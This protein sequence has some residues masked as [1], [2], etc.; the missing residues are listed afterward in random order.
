MIRGSHSR[1][2]RR[3]SNRRRDISILYGEPHMSVANTLRAALYRFGFHDIQ[4]FTSLPPLADAISGQNPDLVILDMALPGGDSC[5]TIRALREGRL[6][7]NPFVPTILSTLNTAPHLVRAA[8]ESGSD[9]LVVKPL[10][11]A[12]VLARIDMLVHNRK[13]FVVTSDYIGPD[14]RRDPQPEDGLPTL[15]VP[16]SLR[17]KSRGLQVDPAEL[18]NAVRIASKSIGRFRLRSHARRIRHL[19]RSI[20]PAYRD[21]MA[22]E[23][24]A[25]LVGRLLDV[26]EDAARLLAGTE[27][28][29]VGAICGTLIDVTASIRREHPEPATKDLALLP[30]LAAAIDLSF[31]PDSGAA[32][33]DEITQSVGTY[34]KRTPGSGRTDA[35]AAEDA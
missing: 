6:G 22:D 4:V 26:A 10:S 31:D 16:N 18:A 2:P 29:H 35:P 15:A 19:V 20:L 25:A 33:A 32:A 17:A 14:R 3:T 1:Q 13:P 28:E 5:K 7:R 12:V 30:R 23:R 11:P 27:F 8:V 34:L 9:D 21:G 24:T